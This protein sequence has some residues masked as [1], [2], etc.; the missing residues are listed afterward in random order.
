MHD[1]SATN[2]RALIDSVRA[3]VKM[4]FNASEQWQWN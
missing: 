4:I 3:S 1:L 2:A